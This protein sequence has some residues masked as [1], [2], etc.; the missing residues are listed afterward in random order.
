[1]TA[2]TTKTDI[3]TR[4]TNLIVADL[5][6][7]VRPWHKPWNAEH[8]AGRISRPLRANGVAYQGINI[9]TLWAEAETRGFVCPCWMT[10][11]QAREL[12]G[13]VRKGEHGTAVVYSSSFTKTETNDSGEEVE[14]NISFLRQYVVFNADQ[15]EGLPER[16]RQMKTEPLP[17]A[18]RI[19][20]ADRFFASTN[21]K[22]RH[23]GNQAYYSAA[24]DHI[25]MPPFVSFRDPESYAATLA[26]ELTHWTHHESRLNR[27]L[28]GKRFAD[29]GYAME[30]LVAELGS[31]FLCADLN[32][33]PEVRDDHAGYI[34]NWLR[35]LKNDK[36]AI[37]T[38]ASM[39]S[40]A[41][42]FLHGLQPS[43]VTTASDQVAAS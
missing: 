25:Q 18:A 15:V 16:F 13:F 20:H 23:G 22:I 41:A 27:N 11:Q 7:G 37:F 26:H 2:Q 36:R 33:T 8:A 4:I 29:E 6:K 31:A 42:E 39:A 30:E 38:A 3:Y 10:F 21:A 24:S 34:A 28:G 35:V 43:E 40:K 32:I 5:E 9:L 12:G 1:M 14:Q 17:L 19:E